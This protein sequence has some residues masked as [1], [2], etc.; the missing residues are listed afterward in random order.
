MEFRKRIL[1]NFSYNYLY[2]QPSQQKNL[3]L[4]FILNTVLQL[5]HVILIIF[6]SLHCIQTVSADRKHLIDRL[7]GFNATRTCR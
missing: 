3:K 4:S 2:I 1:T 7:L 5:I 6:L